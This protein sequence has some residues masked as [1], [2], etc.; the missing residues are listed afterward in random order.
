MTRR[1]SSHNHS[2]EPKNQIKEAIKPTEALWQSRTCVVFQSI[3]SD[4]QECCRRKPPWPSCRTSRSRSRLRSDSIVTREWR[5]L[6]PFFTKL[7]GISLPSLSSACLGT[8]RLVSKRPHNFTVPLLSHR[9]HCAT[10]KFFWKIW[11]SCLTLSTVRRS[12]ISP[13]SR[14]SLGGH[15]STCPLRIKPGVNSMKDETMS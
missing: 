1:S 3:R 5:Q 13:P 14:S 9:S 6:N 11:N 15:Y 12:Y 7:G 8:T 4:N 2:F 10:F